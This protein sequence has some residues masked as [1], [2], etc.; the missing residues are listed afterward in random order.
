M[1]LLPTAEHDMLRDSVTEM[2]Q[3]SRPQQRP[4][5]PYF[6]AESWRELHAA[7]VLD[8]LVPEPDGGSGLGLVD[9]AVVA[10]LCGRTVLAAPL[11]LANAI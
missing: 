1:R 4:E 2:L 7:G 6:D 8:L 5:N 11:L 10:E 9:A 3:R